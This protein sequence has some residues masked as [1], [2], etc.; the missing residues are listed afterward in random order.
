MKADFAKKNDKIKLIFY[1][2]FS[3][4]PGFCRIQGFEKK[5]KEEAKIRDSNDRLQYSSEWCEGMQNICR[6]SGKFAEKL[7]RQ[8]AEE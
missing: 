3:K 4:Y 6:N 8:A 5:K 2:I 7:G 1:G